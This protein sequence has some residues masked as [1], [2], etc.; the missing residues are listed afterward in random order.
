MDTQA[1]VF[2][3]L[4]ILLIIMVVS[5]IFVILS[6]NRSPTKTISWIL[7][8]IFL[9]I[10]GIILYLFFG[11][12]HRKK[13]RIVKKLYKGLDTKYT[14]KYDIHGVNNYP[15]EY[16]K[17]VKMLQNIN[18]A[19]VLDGN[20]ID[21]YASGEE[22]FRHL[23]ADIEKAKHHVHLLYYKIID[24]NIGNRLKDLLIKKVRE[25]V[26]VRLIYDDVGSIKTRNRYFKE[27]Q[28]EGIEVGC[29]L[30]MKLP[31]IARRVNYRNHR[32]LVV[33][34][35]TVGYIGGMNVGDCYIEGLKWGPWRDVQIR[36]EGN[37]VKGLQHVFFSD[38]YFSHKSVPELTPYFPTSESKGDNPLQIIS[39][40]PI[41]IYNSI[42]RGMFQAINSAKESICIQTPYFMPTEKILSALQ[43]ASISGVKIQMIL[44]R[45]SDSF[46][47]DR[48][49]HSFVKD[50]LNYNIKVYL[51]E[52]GF[53]HTKCMV[54]DDCLTILGS[55]NMDTRSFELS[56][57]TDA[58]VYDR[59]TASKAKEIFAEDLTN[60]TEVSRTKW[61]KRHVWRRFMESVMRIFTPLM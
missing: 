29:F 42:E 41:D 21:F 3:V 6:E 8:L 23:F 10:V 48:S 32:K 5:I 53:I 39:S 49:T 27:M 19:P 16:E 17:L 36:I 51:Y 44:P 35:G 2:L 9:P 55:A 14:P 12:E 45:K 52:K 7:V 1:I 43:T 13:Y 28:K 61:D 54:I 50:L 15:P 4:E 30:Q 24:D 22:K 18:F 38:W 40:G 20:K 58:F 26:E 60:S 56:F 46:F 34:D 57:E 25:G 37:G 11:E 33:I 59:E 47:V 31:W